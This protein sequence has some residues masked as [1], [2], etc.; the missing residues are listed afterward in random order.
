MSEINEIFKKFTLNGTQRTNNL[1]NILTSDK[2]E[3]SINRTIKSSIQSNTNIFFVDYAD[4]LMPEQSHIEALSDLQYS[5]SDIVVTPLCSKIVKDENGA[6]SLDN[7]L[8]ITNHFLDVVETLNHKSIMGVIPL[9][10]PRLNIEDVLKN[11][12][13]RDITS[14]V[15]DFD[16]KSVTS[17]GSKIRMLMRLMKEYGILDESFLYGINSNEGKFAKDATE[18][19][20]NDFIASGFGIDIVGMNHVPPNMPSHMWKELEK[21]EP[22]FRLFNKDTYGYHK[23]SEQDAIQLGLS[24]RKMVN[25]FNNTEKHTE[26]KEI[27]SQL[28]KNSSVEGYITTKSQINEKIIRDIKGIRKI[29]YKK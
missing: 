18:V 5:Y 23:I 8:T 24:N 7:F 20:A 27:Q 25:N 14:F 29:V 12:S 6:K 4:S 2:Y 9:K 3:S 16:G 10:I 1:N 15:I 17:T 26:S 28:I 13:D 11:Y 22:T 19:Q 21:K